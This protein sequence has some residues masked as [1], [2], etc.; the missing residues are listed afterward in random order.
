MSL[1]T[2]HFITYQE[3]HYQVGILSPTI[4]I[5]PSSMLFLTG[6]LSLLS[7]LS[8][9]LLSEYFIINWASYHQ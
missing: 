8:L 1:P 9:L 2:M 5:I 4:Y 6:M 3:Y 7:I